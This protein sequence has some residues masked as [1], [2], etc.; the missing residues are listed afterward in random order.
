MFPIMS[1][2]FFRFSL[3]LVLG[4]RAPPFR[5]AWFGSTRCRQHSSASLRSAGVASSIN[6]LSVFT[7]WYPQLIVLQECCSHIPEFRVSPK[8]A[9]CRLY[10]SSAKL[11]KYRPKPAVRS[12]E[13]SRAPFVTQ[14]QPLWPLLSLSPIQGH[15]FG[16]HY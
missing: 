12:N 8:E 14:V 4:Q 9:L 3:Q 7:I 13:S 6:H 2:Y 5:K 1:S 11:Q 15:F 16:F 10:S